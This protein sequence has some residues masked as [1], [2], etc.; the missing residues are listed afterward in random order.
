MTSYIAE[1]FSL[2]APTADCL[3]KQL[4]LLG[5]GQNHQILKKLL[6]LTDD[7]Y[8][9]LYELEPP[10]EADVFWSAAGGPQADQVLHSEETDE[11]NLLGGRDHGEVGHFIIRPKATSDNPRGRD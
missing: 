2:W 8:G 1:L 5:V 7:A 6:L 9:L 4:L 3:K 10:H 11:T